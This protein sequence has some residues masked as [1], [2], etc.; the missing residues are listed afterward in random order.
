MRGL[1]ILGHP[2]L[3]FLCRLALA[4]V[5]LWAGV[6]KA[7]DPKEFGVEIARYRIL[8]HDLVNICAI[9]LPWVEVVLGTALLLGF[10]VRAA[11]LLSGAL[12][13]VFL[14]ALFSALHRGLDI[15]CG[16][17]GGGSDAASISQVTLLRDMLFLFFAGH[18]VLFDRGM[19]SLEGALSQ[20]HGRSAAC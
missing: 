10:W 13:L 5:F 20:R 17:F 11:A 18:V 3:A 19:L 1:K 14:A 7:L 4:G 9:T 15:S 16:C 2:A 8:P 6:T 12:M